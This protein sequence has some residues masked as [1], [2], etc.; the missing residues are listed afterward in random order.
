MQQVATELHVGM[1]LHE[2]T[3]ILQYYVLHKK[4]KKKIP[5]TNGFV[6]ACHTPSLEKAKET[7]GNVITHP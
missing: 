1:Y 5:K 6:M 3:P 7:R 4:A 2:Y